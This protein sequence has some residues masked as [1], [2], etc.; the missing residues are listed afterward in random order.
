MDNL[1]HNTEST[2]ILPDDILIT[3]F[4][5]ITDNN[6]KYSLFQVNSYFNT[7]SNYV[8]IKRQK[9]KNIL[10]SLD[11]CIQTQKHLA[12]IYL[13]N[14]LSTQ[15]QKNYLRELL[16]NYN[17]P[18]FCLCLSIE[19]RNCSINSDNVFV[20]KSNVVSSIYW[21]YITNNCDSLN[22]IKNLILWMVRKNIHTSL[23]TNSLFH[24]RN[25]YSF[26]STV[27]VL[28]DILSIILIEYITHQRK[29]MYKIFIN[30]PVETAAA[31]NKIPMHVLDMFGYLSIINEDER[32]LVGLIKPKYMNDYINNLVRK[33]QYNH[34]QFMM[35]NFMFP[36]QSAE[37]MLKLS[38]RYGKLELCKILLDKY[39]FTKK[40]IN[41]CIKETKNSK[42]ATNRTR[43]CLFAVLK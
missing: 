36:Q 2:Q 35:R 9:I 14:N 5:Y 24:I 31:C 27:G 41:D 15:L 37:L 18:P 33:N 3:I 23:I 7:I 25:K 29:D 28:S 12:G 8:F 17:I 39:K 43:K 26:A 4:G 30:L 19:K 10:G 11:F 6:T 21:N 40:H 34:I 1:L 13:Y 38:G 42:S 16:S 22:S 32:T 20:E